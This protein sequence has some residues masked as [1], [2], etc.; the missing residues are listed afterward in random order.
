MTD[1]KTFSEDQDI[2][3][4]VVAYV[5]DEPVGRIQGISYGDVSEQ[6]HK[7]DRAVAFKI[8]NAYDELVEEDLYDEN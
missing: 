8:D 2:N 1:Y 3:Y 5:N 6:W 4:L 7:L